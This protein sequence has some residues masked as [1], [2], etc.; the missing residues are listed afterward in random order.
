MATPALSS[1]VQSAVA[2]YGLFW[3]LWPQFDGTGSERRLVGLEMELIGS[4]TSDLNHLDP[5][6]SMCNHL[7][8]AQR[9]LWPKCKEACP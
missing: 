3:Q 1:R 6:C 2:E 4:H 7:A 8:S 9:V 5:A